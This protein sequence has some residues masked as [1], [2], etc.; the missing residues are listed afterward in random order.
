MEM[1]VD[2]S[3]ADSQGVW[4]E[5]QLLVLTRFSLKTE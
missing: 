4:L 3:M 5:S 1:I 2:L